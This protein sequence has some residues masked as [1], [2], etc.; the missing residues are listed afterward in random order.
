[1]ANMKIASRLLIAFLFSQITVGCIQKDKQAPNTAQAATTPMNSRG[2][3]SLLE[4]VELRS[5]R[6]RQPSVSGVSSGGF[7]AIQL[8][9]AHSNTFEG[10]GAFAGG[11]YGCAKG[12]K[13]FM[14]LFED[15]K[16]SLMALLGSRGVNE[17]ASRPTIQSIEVCMQRPSLIDVD[18]SVNLARQNE[19]S[20]V[21]DKLANLQNKPVAIFQGDSDPTVLAPSAEKL[22]QFLKR[23]GVRARTAIIPGLGHALPSPKGSL[24]CGTTGTPFLAKCSKQDG[25]I[26]DG[27]GDVLRTIYGQLRPRTEMDPSSLYRFSQ[28]QL[29]NA[30]SATMSSEGFIY[31]PKACREANSNCRL[32]VALH[33]CH[34]NGDAV[35]DEF[36]RNAGYNEWAEA[37]GIVVLYPNAAVS[38]MANP[39]SIPFKRD[40][41]SS[42]FGYNPNGCWDWFAYTGAFYTTQEAP[43]IEAIK[44]MV[45]F[46]MK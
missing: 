5:I 42:S 16:K 39:M 33:G 32:H 40:D 8:L 22:D 41:R 17:G 36:A 4:P 26:V 19:A 46:L 20:G 13:D 24:E 25:S 9:V 6:A 35:G 18:F 31:W 23:F 3:A 12:Q 1:M 44:K 45:D 15:N 2:I 30:A 34:Q 38:Q 10:A 37:N 28:S 43:Q 21:I 7:M 29:I 11:I 27:A 14:T